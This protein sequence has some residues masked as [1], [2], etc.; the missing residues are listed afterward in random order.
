MNKKTAKALERP[1]L[2]ARP[3]HMQRV[4]NITRSWLTRRNNSA[5]TP[6]PV[7]ISDS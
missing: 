5:P 1:G 2:R 6:I 3:Q 4:A 7:A